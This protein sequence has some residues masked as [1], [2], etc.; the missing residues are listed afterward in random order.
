[1][2]TT[3]SSLI[4]CIK[5]SLISSGQAGYFYILTRTFVTPDCFPHSHSHSRSL[6]PSVAFIMHCSRVCGTVVSFY[7]VLFST[8]E[9]CY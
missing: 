8:F 9:S 3:G 7:L 2:L 5:D 4:W 6:L 1:M